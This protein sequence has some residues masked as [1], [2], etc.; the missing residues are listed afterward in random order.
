MFKRIQRWPQTLLA[1]MLHE[2]A[3]FHDGSFHQSRSCMPSGARLGL[4]HTHR[5]LGSETLEFT[6]P[7]PA[8]SSQCSWI[9]FRDFFTLSGP[10]EIEFL[11]LSGNL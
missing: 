6:V 3:L 2:P 1:V 11:P 9:S 4:L 7:W 10:E 5:S 8:D